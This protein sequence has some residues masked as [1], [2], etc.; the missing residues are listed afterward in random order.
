MNVQFHFEFLGKILRV[1]RLEASTHRKG[2]RVFYQFSSFL[3]D[4]T[5]RG[6]VSLK[7]YISQCKA[8][9]VTVNSKEENSFV[10][11]SSKNS[12]SGET[13]KN[14][15][16]IYVCFTHGGRHLE[17]TTLYSIPTRTLSNYEIRKGLSLAK[18]GEMLLTVDTDP[19]R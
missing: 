5:V 10:W 13:T 16:W 17:I 15:R 9:E 6:C 4:R 18:C 8:I 2:G 1:L 19:G 14:I 3:L 7:K 12:A 11:I